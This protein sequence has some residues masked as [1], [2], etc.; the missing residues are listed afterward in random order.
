MINEFLVIAAAYLVSAMFLMAIV[1]VIGRRTDNYGV[2]DIAWAGGFSLLAAGTAL[3][4]SG[5]AVRRTLIAV[6]VSGWSVRLAWHLFRR[7]RKHHPEEDGR[8]HDLRERWGDNTPRNMFLFFQIQGVLL[9]VLALPFAWI[10][11][12]PN[13]T[14]SPF[15][16]IGAAMWLGAFIGES[17]AD[18]QLDRFKAD[19][20]NRGKTCRLGLWRYSR[21]PNYFFE[22]MMWVSWFVIACGSPQGWLSIYAPI[23]MLHFLVNVTGIRPTELQALKSRGAD[24]RDYQRTTSPFVPWFNRTQS[25]LT[26]KS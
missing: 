15:E 8:Y 7:V 23:I 25:Q 5:M 10:S 24:Y 20:G 3:A 2:V 14:L 19:P 12:N 1:W 17:V 4:A 18:R 22:W 13:P 11:V 21:H 6:T 16:W 9:A 26:A